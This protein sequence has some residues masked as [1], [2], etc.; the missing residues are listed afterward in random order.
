MPAHRI[1]T[2]A[3][4]V[5]KHAVESTIGLTFDFR[6]ERSQTFLPRFG[7]VII[8]RVGVADAGVPMKVENNSSA[9][10]WSMKSRMYTSSPAGARAFTQRSPEFDSAFI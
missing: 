4:Q 2:V 7:M 1:A 3:V 8:A 10:A 9:R 5:E 6:P